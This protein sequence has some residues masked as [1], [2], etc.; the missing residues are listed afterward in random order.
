M[1][2]VDQARVTLNLIRTAT[3]AY[4]SRKASR[5]DRDPLVFVISYNSQL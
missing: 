2:V 4:T 5:F 3:T 1:G